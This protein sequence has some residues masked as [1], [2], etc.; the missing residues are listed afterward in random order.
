MDLIEKVL[1][2]HGMSLLCDK[3]E[4]ASIMSK[5]FKI[6][7]TTKEELSIS[8]NFYES[9][10]ADILNY[11][12][13]NDG[14]FIDEIRS[15]YHDESLLE[16]SVFTLVEYL[17]SPSKEIPLT[18]GAIGAL[19]HDLGKSATRD[20]IEVSGKMTLVNYF[21][22]EIG[23]SFLL[24]AWNGELSC[25]AYSKEDWERMARGVCIH[26]NLKNG[27]KYMVQAILEIEEPSVKDYL[28][29]L[30]RADTCSKI[31]EGTYQGE[32]RYPE[33]HLSPRDVTSS[34]YSEKFDRVA[35]I[36]RGHSASGKTT[37]AKRIINQLKV[38]D[39]ESCLVSRDAI[40]LETCRVKNP[41]CQYNEAFKFVKEN[42]L[43][44]DVNKRFSERIEASL[45]E[46]NFVVIDTVANLYNSFIPVEL[47]HRC[48]T[49]A[50]DCVR[51]SLITEKDADRIGVDLHTQLDLFGER[52]LLSWVPKNVD[53][54]RNLGSKFSKIFPGKSSHI[55][56]EYVWNND[57][58]LGYQQIERTFPIVKSILEKYKIQE[59]KDPLQCMNLSLPS[60]VENL[61]SYGGIPY[62]VEY[63]SL[64]E[65]RAQ[66][67][68]EIPGGV[69]M[70]VEYQEGCKC[71]NKYAVESRGCYLII[72]G[73]GV[74]I[75]K[76]LLPR[77][78]ECHSAPYPS[79]G[80]ILS[81]KVD[82]SLIGVSF[83]EEDSLVRPFAEYLLKKSTSS[84]VAPILDFYNEKKVLIIPSTRGT[85]LIGNDMLGYFSKAIIEGLS[86]QRS[87]KPLSW[88]EE[89]PHVLPS[90][91]DVLL[92]LRRKIPPSKEAHLSFEAVCA[93]RTGYD[94]VIHKELAV[95]YNSSSFTFL[96]A[97]FLNNGED[98]QYVPSFNYLSQ[99]TSSGIQIP[100]FWEI[101]KGET[102][103]E[104]LMDAQAVCI[105]KITK[106][107]FLSLHKPVSG[108]SFDPEGFVQY[109]FENGSWKY[110]KI[111]TFAYH[112]GHV[113]SKDKIQNL[114]LSTG[115][116]SFP[117][118]EEVKKSYRIFSL[119][120][121]NFVKT[122]YEI[123]VKE[124]PIIVSKD[125]PFFKNLEKNPF[126]IFSKKIKEY[127]PEEYA[128]LYSKV[129]GTL[130]ETF[131]ENLLKKEQILL[132]FVSKYG[133]Q[134]I[135]GGA[136]NTFMFS[137]EN[138]INDI[139]ITYCDE[140]I[141]II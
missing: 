136:L 77:G 37:I 7:M 102:A 31:V 80:G 101:P 46:K 121:E 114:L 122:L 109:T 57:Y 113:L 11:M 84:L 88:L 55:V 112:N 78:E 124:I 43:N 133:M 108:T 131:T 60:L 137:P 36:L 140:D 68:E 32:R 79:T 3:L 91:L 126:I 106:D 22:Q 34:K 26:M 15:H 71:W 28:K 25:I 44:D 135:T 29:C 23:C 17:K 42:H 20:T 129:N 51:Q 103:F 35:I 81:S 47:G 41:T 130:R 92:A 56:Y 4:L 107:K 116:S 61:Y 13:E 49:I 89:V 111:K 76:Y 9:T 66:I 65:I 119:K 141:Q 97:A 30:V 38:P 82:G 118:I 99:A 6:Y 67:E 105:D 33:I 10:L 94:G 125:V 139:F 14:H 12:N 73:N 110:T 69:I 64:R 83:Y 120:M 58:D 63:L 95:S 117:L 24:S 52:S 127:I 39:G 98:L 128:K 74:K 48:L 123:L 54:Y 59:E 27:F 138:S 93:S 96:G 53:S 115:G 75:L 72:D 45:K 8:Q 70:R 16:H 5:K 104:H 87:W 50:I 62:V 18:I 85:S 21:H 86:L 90:F 1:S 40:I 134:I 100:T 2:K 132:G 19:F